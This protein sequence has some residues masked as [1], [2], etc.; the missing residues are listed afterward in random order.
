MVFAAFTFI[1]NIQTQV[2][3][4]SNWEIELLPEIEGTFTG[5]R[6]EE[7]TDTAWPYTVHDS[8]NSEGY[9]VITYTIDVTPSFS[10]VS[11][12]SITV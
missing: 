12:E 1:S 10:T 4:V 7:E 5:L 3:E 8:E 11:V 6:P 2:V 9:V